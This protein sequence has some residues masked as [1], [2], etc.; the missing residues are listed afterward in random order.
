MFLPAHFLVKPAQLHPPLLATH[1]TEVIIV[2][3]VLA[4]ALRIYPAVKIILAKLVPGS[5]T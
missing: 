2:L 5:I 3:L 1:A 4:P